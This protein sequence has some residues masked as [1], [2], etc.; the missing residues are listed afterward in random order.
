VIGGFTPP[1]NS[2]LYFGSILIGYFAQ[3]KLLYCGKV[4]SGFD[5]RWLATLHAKFMKLA[6]SKPPFANLP[7]A[8]RPRFGQGMTPAVMRTVT[9]LKPQLV[10]QIKFAEWTQDGILRQPVFL[11]LRADKSAKQVRREVAVV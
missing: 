2:R 9:W 1:R 10:A 7:L 3:G 5:G 6:V 11:G 4:G 8:K